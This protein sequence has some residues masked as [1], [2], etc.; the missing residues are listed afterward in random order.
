MGKNLKLQYVENSKKSE[1]VGKSEKHPKLKNK[2]ENRKSNVR[3]KSSK[4][5]KIWRK[6]LEKNAE[7]IYEVRKKIRQK[8]K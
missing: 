7:K 2:T 1:T 5:K 8:M 4:T 3:I 6:K